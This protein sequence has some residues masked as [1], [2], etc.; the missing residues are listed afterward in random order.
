MRT[1]PVVRT[2]RTAKSARSLGV[3]SPK[4]NDHGCNDYCDQQDRNHGTLRFGVNQ[5]PVTA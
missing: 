4:H 2:G 5:R 3:H 1:T